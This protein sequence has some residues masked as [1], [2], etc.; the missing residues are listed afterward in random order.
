MLIFAGVVA[1]VALVLVGGLVF[2][3]LW[4]WFAVP[5]GAPAIGLLH[6]L[7][8]RVLCASVVYHGAR[9]DEGPARLLIEGFVL[10]AMLLAFGWIFSLG[11]QP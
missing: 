9:R 7:G 11:V 6:G 10:Q 2:V 3:Q 4:A 5:L 8:L 1:W